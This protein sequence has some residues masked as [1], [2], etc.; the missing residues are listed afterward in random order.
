[1]LIDIP[2]I[3]L[4]RVV[5]VG[6]G[7]A[8]IE[9]A[10]QLRNTHQVVMIDKNNY[11]TFQPLLYQVATAGI[12]ADS[13]AFPLRKIFKGQKHFYFRMAEA[14][15]IL[16]QQNTLRTSVG[17]ITYDFMVIATGADTSYFGMESLKENSMPMKSVREALELRS[18]ILSNFEKAVGST[19]PEERSAL[20]TY[21]IA[22]GGPTGVELAG[23]LGELKKH[24]LP[25]DYPEL[26]FKNMQIHLV[27]PGERL[28][29]SFGEKAS[30]KARDYLEMLGVKIW[31]G[32]RVT[33]YDGKV[34]TTNKQTFDTVTMIWAAGVAGV[35]IPGI[36]ESSIQRN[37]RVSVDEMNGVAGTE[38]IFAVGDVASMTTTEFPKGHPQVAQVAIQQATRLGKNLAS[39]KP[40][41]N[42]DKFVYKDK[43]SMAT[44]GMHRAVVESKFITTQGFIAWL[45]WIFVHLMALVGFRNRLV[46]FF[47]WLISYFNYDHG[48]RLIIRPSQRKKKQ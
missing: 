18:M 10:K 8:G 46:V 27:D 19:S 15:E 22:G 48:L 32:V 44:V 39:N 45:L 13:I 17:D 28:L 16:P 47:N 14:L 42:W 20:M 4:K 33:N 2:K 5:I 40:K 34:V 37:G 41:K 7:F 35:S 23:A 9:L 30:E 21:V 25:N 24:V 31:L 11:H 36:P 6:G 29:N 38:N 3:Y 12:E 1:M 43:G 26:D